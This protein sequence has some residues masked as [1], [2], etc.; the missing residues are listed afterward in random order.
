MALTKTDTGNPIRGIV[1]P[2]NAQRSDCQDVIAQLTFADLGRGAGTLH[3]SGNARLDL[4]GHTANGSV[5]LQVQ[6]GGGTTAAALVAP[7]VLQITDPINQRGGANGAIS[8][9]NQSL[10]SGTVWTLTG[11]LP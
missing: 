9:L 4:Q 6:I 3:T 2:N 8:V 5:N 1:I 7:T 11:T 10:D